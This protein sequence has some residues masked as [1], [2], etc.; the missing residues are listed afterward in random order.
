[1]DSEPV[2]AGAKVLARRAP[3]PVWVRPPAV[4][5]STLGVH[6]T[7]RRRPGVASR[8]V[9]ALRPPRHIRHDGVTVALRM[10]EPGR[11]R[12]RSWRGVGDPMGASE[13]FHPTS[14]HRHGRSGPRCRATPIR[15][16]PPH[17]TIDV[18][19]SERPGEEQPI[20]GTARRPAATRV[21]GRFRHDVKGRGCPAAAPLRRPPPRPPDLERRSC[22]LPARRPRAGAGTARHP[23]DDRRRAGRRPVSPRGRGGVYC[24]RAR[25]AAALRA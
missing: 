6:R 12:S 3:R 25:R 5:L 13:R 24:A 8:P 15:M 7:G 17:R 14:R 4:P 22:P 1:M 16:D 9:H 10:S 21:G 20:R 11:E 2:P 19:T 18:E 23:H